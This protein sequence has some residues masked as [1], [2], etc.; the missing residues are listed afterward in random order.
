MTDAPIKREYDPANLDAPTLG[1]IELQNATK[2]FGKK[3]AFE[4][5][6]FSIEPGSV[7]A[8]L[9]EN[10]AG[11][12]TT[13]RLLLGEMEPTSGQVRVFQN[14]PFDHAL[15]N[16]ARIGFVPETPVLYDYMTVAEI[17]RFA[18][19]FY[20]AGFMAEYAKRCEEFGLAPDDK[21]KSISKGMRAKT[22]LALALA[23]DPELLILDEPT[24]GLDA[25]VRRQFLANIADLA[26]VGKTVFLSSHQ[27]AE[28]ERVANRVAFLKDKKLI[29]NE[30]LDALKESSQTIVA[31]ILGSN[32]RDDSLQTLFS[33]VFDKLVGVER[34]GA[35]HRFLGRGLVKNFEERIRVALG[36]RLA[37][38]SVVQPNL[39]EIFIAYM[40]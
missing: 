7:F 18:S 23:H 36:E 24:S 19:A 15:E 5:V 14:N 39:E 28:V 13:I 40:S 37:E 9:G 20:P 25:L 26:A 3:T 17:G 34:Y 27:T 29:V 33:S 30:P 1:V 38:I 32:A 10:G 4:N 2:K 35:R 12:T 21:I 11:K 8:L 16:R 31:T 22:S 6:S